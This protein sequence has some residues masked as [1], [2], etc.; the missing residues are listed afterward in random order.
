MYNLLW[1]FLM[2]WLYV[3]FIIV[4]IFKN[5]SQCIS[6]SLVGK[7]WTRKNS[8]DYLYV[9]SERFK[10]A[11]R[12]RIIFGSKE[13]TSEPFLFFRAFQ[14]VRTP[15]LAD[16]T[17]KHSEP[18]WKFRKEEFICQNPE[19]CRCRTLQAFKKLFARTLAVL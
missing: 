9:R 13:S 10:Y 1:I 2:N 5:L 4:S 6:I 12:T 17:R 18:S 19:L 3:K 11:K 15:P 14:Q 8:A 7:Y 16:P